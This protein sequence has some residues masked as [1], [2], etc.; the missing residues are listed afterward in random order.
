MVVPATTSSEQTSRKEKKI[1]EARID[2]ESCKGTGKQRTR[3]NRGN[4]AE[5]REVQPSHEI[6][7]GN[8][9]IENTGNIINHY[10]ALQQSINPRSV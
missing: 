6:T 3:G 8:G 9:K 10:V 1:I 4:I 5:F 2:E 7:N